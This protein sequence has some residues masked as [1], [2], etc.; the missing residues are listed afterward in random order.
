MPILLV[1]LVAAACLQLPWPAPPF[2]LGPRGSLLLTAAAT[3]VPVAASA[4]LSRWVVRTLRRDPAR[5]AEVLTRYARLRR[6]LGYANLLVAAVAVV[7]LGWGHTVWTAGPR[8]DLGFGSTRLVPL[9]ELLVPAPYF[10]ALVAGWVAAYFAERALYRGGDREFWSLPGYLLF[11]GR[12]FALLVMVPVGVFAGQQSLTRVAPAVVAS[13]WFQVG[14]VVGALVLFVLLPRVVK[15]ALG[16]KPLPPGPT[17]ERLERTARRLGFRY[18]D[19]LVWPTRGA[20]A[21]ALVVGVVP[22]A[23]YVVF[24]DRLLEGLTPDELDAVFGHEVGHVKHLHIPY[25]AGF[26]VLSAAVGTAA[27]ALLGRTVDQAGWTVPPE[28]S[29]WLVL[30]PV[31]AMA[32]Y[33]FVVFGLLS[34][35]CERQA[36]VFG[37]RAGSC[38]DPDCGGHDEK[39]QLAPAGRGLCRTGVLALVRA[40]DRVYE[41]NGLDGTPGRRRLADRGWALVKAWQHGPVSDRIEFLLRLTEDPRLGD[42]TDRRVLWFRVVLAAALVAMLGVFG[43]LVGWSDLWRML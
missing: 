37:G 20:M 31:L 4:A 8:L 34:R 12:Q 28:W 40:L 42:R 39:T 2:G 26:F 24:T 7:G 27:L 21:N 30:P 38:R 18:T 36:D 10:A 32:A 25:Y 11:N 13:D 43:S 3:L 5:R 35:R 6:L 23:R 9:A 16:L 41:L 22:W 19:L 29:G 17:R 14:S 15:P 1:L 33:V